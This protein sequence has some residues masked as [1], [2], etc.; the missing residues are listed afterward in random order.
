MIFPCSKKHKNEFS[1]VFQ[2][3]CSKKHK[4][5]FRLFS[6]KI[7]ASL[8]DSLSHW[9]VPP[10]SKTNVFCFRK[11]KLTKPETTETE[12]AIEKKFFWF[13]IKYH[14]CKMNGRLFPFPYYKKTF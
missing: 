8:Y 1:V 7:A 4:I 12:K 13:K 3:S 9:E 11:L 2:K 10:L 6:P 14:Q 5:N